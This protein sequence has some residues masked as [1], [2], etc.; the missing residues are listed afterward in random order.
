[1]Q[2][3]LICIQIHVKEPDWGCGPLRKKRG[4]GIVSASPDELDFTAKGVRQAVLE[5]DTGILHKTFR[6]WVCK[7]KGSA[8]DD[9]VLE[10]PVLNQTREAIETVNQAVAGIGYEPRRPPDPDTK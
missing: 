7:R 6:E 5:G 3:T 8:L 9:L 4:Q 10:F 2:A 1:M